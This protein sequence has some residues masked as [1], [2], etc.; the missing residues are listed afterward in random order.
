SQCQGR[1]PEDL[2]VSNRSWA[3]GLGVERARYLQGLPAGQADRASSRLD[4][5]HYAN[6]RESLAVRLQ[7]EPALQTGAL[8]HLLEPDGPAALRY[9]KPTRAAGTQAATTLLG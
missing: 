8:T 7:G 5:F 3:R 6:L 4:L 9:S 1:I 2:A